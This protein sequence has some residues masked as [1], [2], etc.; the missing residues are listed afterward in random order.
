MF[1]AENSGIVLRACDA[2]ST[3]AAFLAAAFYVLSDVR[4]AVAAFPLC[5]R[6]PYFSAFGFDLGQLL[7]FLG[8]FRIRN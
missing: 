5:M 4:N 1:E 2:A 8:L 6:K 7:L 3:L